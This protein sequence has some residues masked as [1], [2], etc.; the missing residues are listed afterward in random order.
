M[1]HFQWYSTAPRV[2]SPE[3][4]PQLCH[5]KD[6][7]KVVQDASMLSTHWAITKAHLKHIVLR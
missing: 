3:F 4:N 1:Q 5:T 7:I 6:V 2:G